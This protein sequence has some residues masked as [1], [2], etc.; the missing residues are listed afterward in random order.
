MKTK[1]ISKN[2]LSWKKEFLKFNHMSKKEKISKTKIC[3]KF[4]VKNHLIDKVIIGFDNFKQF[5]E[6]TTIKYNQ[7]LKLNYKFKTNNQKL[8]NP[9][10]W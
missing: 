1:K 7:N 9:S 2:F 10:K 3:T 6:I 4:V 8:I 5:K